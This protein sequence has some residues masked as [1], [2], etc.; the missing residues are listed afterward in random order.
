MR[1]VPT[2]AF[3]NTAD[4]LVPAEVNKTAQLQRLCRVMGAS[5][6]AVLVDGTS[7]GAPFANHSFNGRGTLV[8]DLITKF[9][10]SGYKVSGKF[11]TRH[12]KAVVS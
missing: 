9:L 5:C 11:D 2:L 12:A 7:T 1:G 6:S 3:L 8:S 10:K 4:E